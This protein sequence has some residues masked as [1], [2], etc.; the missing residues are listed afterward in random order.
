[1]NLILYHMDECPYCAKVRDAISK[2]KIKKLIEYREID[3]EKYRDE[4]IDLTDDYQ[5][6]CLVIDGKPMLE[7]E[8]IIIFLKEKFGGKK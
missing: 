6:P 3:N 8:D 2:L 4:L 7:S 5:V 1:M